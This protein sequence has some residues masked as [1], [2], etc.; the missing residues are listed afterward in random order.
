MRLQISQTYISSKGSVRDSFPFQSEQI[1]Q[2][3]QYMMMNIRAFC[4]SHRGFLKASCGENGD[5][6]L[7]YGHRGPVG[8]VLLLVSLWGAV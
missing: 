8:V 4:G 7:F 1:S 5:G 6:P 3:A 2:Q